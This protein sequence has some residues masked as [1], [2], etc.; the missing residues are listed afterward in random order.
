MNENHP[1]NPAGTHRSILG[2]KSWKRLI[3]TYA[4]S[5]LIPVVL[6]LVESQY[7]VSQ[8]Q[9]HTR[10]FAPETQ[11]VA[12]ADEV[13]KTV[14]VWVDTNPNM[15]G[16]VYSS[17]ANCIPSAYSKLLLN[18][19]VNLKA[20]SLSTEEQYHF[21]SKSGQGTLSESYD[22][23][24]ESYYQDVSAGYE[25]NNRLISLL[26]AQTGDT[27]ALFFTDFET[28]NTKQFQNDLKTVAQKLFQQGI[29]LRMD[30]FLS[31][32]S[33]KIIN[34]AASNDNF[35]YGVYGN[36]NKD[37]YQTEIAG[38]PYYHNLPRP[39]YV[40][41]VGTEADCE[42][43]GQL[44]VNAYNSFYS[45]LP[46]IDCGGDHDIDDYQA[47]DVF[48]YT[49]KYPTQNALL[50]KDQNAGCSVGAVDSAIKPDNS[51][52]ESVY[53]FAVSQSEQTAE[54][55]FVLSPQIRGIGQTFML[56]VVDPL[57]MQISK[58]IQSNVYGMDTKNVEQYLEA[59]GNRY[60][61]LTLEPQNT[62]ISGFSAAYKIQSNMDIQI[63]LRAN[64]LQCAKGL[65]RI[66][67]PVTCAP[68]ITKNSSQADSNAQAN[69]SQTRQNADY[70]IRRIRSSRKL[71]TNVF[72][73]TIDFDRIISSLHNAY[74]EAESTR[75]FP[76]G[77]IEF[78]LRIQ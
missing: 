14:D 65:Y 71:S 23:G 38:L 28:Y 60:I 62:G 33:G 61:K 10:A 74:V 21:F 55:P 13:T 12:S 34:Y 22:I 67:I 48:T 40:L 68:D 57:Q 76:V 52:N 5:V 51:G 66:R 36:H 77:E 27:P 46:S 15:Y 18:M 37:A 9:I 24:T 47:H 56:T 75:T 17:V 72:A 43:L 20:Y 11:L 54:I 2:H 78:D 41:T 29:S 42:T 32:Y 30:A 26:E 64:L 63:T 6:L 49:V 69:W 16:F 58:V 50:L 1:R 44:L 7:F 59:R 73:K 70:A 19:Q 3:V 4:I 53:G 25:D 39:F 45:N 8:D 31:A 35:Y